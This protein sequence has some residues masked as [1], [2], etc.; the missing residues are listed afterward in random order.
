MTHRKETPMITA[1]VK[2]LLRP[3]TADPGSCMITSA[4]MAERRSRSFWTEAEP[5][6]RVTDR[7]DRMIEAYLQIAA[8]S[9]SLLPADGIRLT[10][11]MFLQ[12][13]R[14][15]M[16]AAMKHGHLQLDDV[17]GVFRV[18]AQGWSGSKRV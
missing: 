18:T 1:E 11:G 5:H 7:T 13:D 8:R 4:P 9:G 14:A 15:V 12:P 2:A 6:K 17:T 10:D 3:L 16:N